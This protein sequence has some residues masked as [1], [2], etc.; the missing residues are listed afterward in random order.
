MGIKTKK[1]ARVDAAIGAIVADGFFC[2]AFTLQLLNS[3]ATALTLGDFLE[4]GVIVSVFL[5]SCWVI[6]DEYWLAHHAV[7]SHVVKTLRIK[8]LEQGASIEFDGKRYRVDNIDR[9]NGEIRIARVGQ[10]GSIIV[11]IEAQG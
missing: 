4:M 10:P 9:T 7:C 5:T 11:Q 3:Q 1:Q 8:E 2:A 6:Y